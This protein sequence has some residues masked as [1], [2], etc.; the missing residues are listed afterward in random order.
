MKKIVIVEDDTVT[1][2]V[3]R[4]M[5][6]KAG[7][8][9]EVAANGQAGLDRVTQGALDGML[10]DLMMPGLSGIELVKRVRAMPQFQK[11]PVICYTNAFVPKLVDEAK[12]AGATRVFD[13]STMTPTMLVEAFTAGMNA[14]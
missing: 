10:V 3:Y 6:E 2:K 5:L 12:A 13:K 11:I 8:E 1:A 7:F 14:S 4:T 9:I